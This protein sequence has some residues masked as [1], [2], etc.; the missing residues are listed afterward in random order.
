MQEQMLPAGDVILV[1]GIAAG[2]N[3]LGSDRPDM[4]HASKEVCPEMSRQSV[5]NHKRISTSMSTPT[6]P[7]AGARG[8]R[9]VED[10]RCSA[11]IA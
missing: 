7:A 1:R 6:G 8:N 2:A 4:L 5:G 9:Q 11:S 10:A 3:Y